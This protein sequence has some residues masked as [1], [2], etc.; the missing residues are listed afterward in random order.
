MPLL[1]FLGLAFLSV[2]EG[3]PFGHDEAVYALR[4][5]WATGDHS[6][7]LS[8]YWL[9]YRAPGLPWVLS[10]AWLVRSTEP[11]LRLVV[12]VFGAV[13][14]GLTWWLARELFGARAATLASA[15]LALSPFWISPSTHVWPD[16]PGAVLGFATM[17]VLVWATRG[18]KVSWWAVLA[19]PL[20]VLTTIVRFG[21][22]LSLA[23][24]AVALVWWRWDA[25][26][27]SAPVVAVTG[28]VAA[29]GTALVLFTT[30]VTDGEETPYGAMALLRSGRD[31]TVLDG[32]AGYW[33]LAASEF[34]TPVAVALFAG[35]TAAFLF[36]WS[37]AARRNLVFVGFVS[38]ATFAILA[39]SLQAEL[40]Y[41]S[42]VFPFLWMFA[43]YG[44][45]E[46]SR[47]WPRR[48]LVPVAL[49]VMI[50]F[51]L[52][53]TAKS[54]EGNQVLK[55]RFTVLKDTMAVVDWPDD[56]RIATSFT[57]QVGW[58]SHCQVVGLRHDGVPVPEP[59][60]ITHIVD[61]YA[62]GK[63]PDSLDEWL[64]DNAVEVSAY[65]DPGLGAL[66]AVR[67]LVPKE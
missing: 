37:G 2:R 50:P 18:E 51:L 33:D 49:V 32:F 38:V 20:A 30:M 27:Q 39:G 34:A 5:E 55:E 43:G 67:I 1:V 31:R 47:Q 9:G 29:A 53:A 13:G 8:G 59:D 46:L 62:S 65:G 60:R 42:P 44:L 16:V 40:R 21:A 56:C 3:A 57:P 15:G 63:E 41:L 61:V 64:E 45:A 26:K 24:A 17:V 19:G 22:P 52:G 58:Y 23:V 7:N 6:V 54:N 66:R 25:V 14:I 11:Y 12:S 35:V 10:L 28:I 48:V 36:G 4:A